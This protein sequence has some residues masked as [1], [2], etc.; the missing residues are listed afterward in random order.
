[1]TNTDPTRNTV[2]QFHALRRANRKLTRTELSAQLGVSVQRISN[3]AKAEK[4]KLP[5]GRKR[6]WKNRK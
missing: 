1:M 3:I 5:D 2:A 4:V 6:K